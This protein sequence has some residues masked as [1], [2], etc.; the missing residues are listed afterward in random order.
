MM[1]IVHVRPG[2]ICFLD[3]HRTWERGTRDKQDISKGRSQL[4]SRRT[5]KTAVGLGGKCR[6]PIGRRADGIQ[7]QDGTRADSQQAT[8]RLQIVGEDE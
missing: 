6:R 8:G 2:S 4:K 5:K 3:R 1:G 7:A